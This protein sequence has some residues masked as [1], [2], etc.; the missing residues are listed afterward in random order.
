M[1]ACA[2]SSATARD[3][4]GPK[5]ASGVASGVTIETCASSMP[6]DRTSRTVMSASS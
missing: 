5:T 4:T 6:I 2:S 1:P 3:A